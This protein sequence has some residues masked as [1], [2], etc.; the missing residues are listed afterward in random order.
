MQEDGRI[1]K[2]KL[3][4]NRCVETRSRFLLCKVGR[5][6]ARRIKLMCAGINQHIDLNKLSIGKLC[7]Y[8]LHI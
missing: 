8:V 7:A 1:V 4:I 5:S 3:N 6:G 2:T